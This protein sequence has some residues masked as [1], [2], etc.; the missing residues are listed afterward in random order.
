M[1]EIGG[2]LELELSSGKEY[3]SN[4]ISVNTARNAFVYIAKA[5]KIKKVFLPYF[6]CDSVS[7][8]CEREEIK[9]SFYHIDRQFK[10][11]IDFLLGENQYLYIVNYYGQ[12]SNKEIREFKTKYK[13]IIID[14]VQAF[15]Q[16]PIEKIDTIYS[17]RKYFGVSDGA[18]LSTEKRCQ[19]NIETDISKD[20]MK[21]ILGRFESS[22][23][24]YYSDF[25]NNDESFKGLPL[26][27]MSKLTHNLLSQI[28]YP[29]VMQKRNENWSFLNK[30]LKSKNKLDLI[31]TGAPYCYPFYIK[32]GINIK[33][34]LSTKKIYIPTLWPNV[35]NQENC[36]EKDYAENILPLP[37][38][39]RY[40][41]EEITYLLEELMKCIG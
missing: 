21:H 15:F 30:Q 8:V 11:I 10:P 7:E 35:L 6:L 34:Q 5:K 22:A 36:I 9:Y 23:S 18:Y 2:Y 19:E 29:K 28:D 17:C 3:Y 20:R 14:N 37:I 33:K 31:Q 27:Y 16:E 24:D 25:H 4:L 40:G 39:Q 41:L 38:D 12:I 32:N 1:K 13:N 26:K